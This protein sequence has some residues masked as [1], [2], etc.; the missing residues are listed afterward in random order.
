VGDGGVDV[1]VGCGWS[2]GVVDE[3]WW[4]DASGADGSRCGGRFQENK[5]VGR[6]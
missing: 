4:W 2:G 1:E 5:E 6:A 3:Q